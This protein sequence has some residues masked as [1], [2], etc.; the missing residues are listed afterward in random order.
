MGLLWS[1]KLAQSGL[2]VSC[3][4]RHSS[5]DT[6][7]I[8][9]VDKRSKALALPVAFCSAAE[10][11]ASKAQIDKLIIATKS[12]DVI[13]A[14]DSIK[15]L[16]TSDC[17]VFFLANGIGYQQPAVNLLKPLSDRI[18]AFQIVS[19]DGALKNAVN[20]VTHTGYGDNYIGSLPEFFESHLADGNNLI[21]SNQAL[22]ELLALDNL[23]TSYSEQIEKQR[24]NKLLVN[25]VINPL[26]LYYRCHNGELVTNS[27][28]LSHT[29]KLCEEIQVGIDAA[30][31]CVD[32]EC[33][34]ELVKKVASQTSAN[35]SSMLRDGELKRRTEAE[36]MNLALSTWIREH[37]GK[38]ELQDELAALL[39]NANKP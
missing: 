28:Y 29:R 35:R 18:K 3:I 9:N 26:T 13:D 27:H 34:F 7:I 30:N 1:A 2:Q 11:E 10:L 31:S 21:P 36:F 38:T 14:L 32:Q 15:F 25:A 24:F 33:V 22:T 17:S 19:S 5:E 37:G 20:E 23:N 16:L 4:H 39:F 8:L 6:H 12:F